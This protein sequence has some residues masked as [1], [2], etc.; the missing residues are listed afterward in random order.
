MDEGIALEP[1]A[2]LVT[3]AIPD[4]GVAARM[5]EEAHAPQVQECRAAPAAHVLG[6]LE[7][8]VVGA[9]DIRPIGAEIAQMWPI[10][11]SLLHPVARRADADAEAVVLAAEQ[12]RHPQPLM[13]VVLGGVQGPQGGRVVERC[14]TERCDHDRVLW[15]RGFDADPLGAFDREPDPHRT[16]QMRRDGRGLR[17]HR[18]RVVAEHLVSPAGDRLIRGGDQAEEDV[19]QRVGV[20]DLLCP[21]AVEPARSVVEERRVGGPQRRGHRGVGL[22]TRG[23]DRVNAWA[24]LPQVARGEVEVSARNHRVEQREGHLSGQ[25]GALADRLVELGA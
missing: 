8:R 16:G 20:R 17:D 5:T 10:R 3:A 6:R 1:L 18:E 25:P 15:P 2:D 19:P 24:L 12:H 22:V 23:S 14:I 21:R 9:R 13:H 7:G 4:L 11:P